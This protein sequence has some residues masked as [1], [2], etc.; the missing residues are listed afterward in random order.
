MKRLM[1][2]FIRSPQ[3]IVPAVS[4]ATIAVL[5]VASYIT[6]G[7]YAVRPNPWGEFRIRVI[8]TDF[9]AIPGASLRISSPDDPECE[10]PMPFGRDHSRHEWTSDSGGTIVIIEPRL[11]LD[12][13]FGWSLFW[14]IPMGGRA[15]LFEIEVLADGYETARIPLRRFCKMAREIPDGPRRHQGKEL[16]VFEMSVPLQKARK[17]DP[18]K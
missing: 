3:F 7:Y 4:L 18:G 9:N 1:F 15:E 6:T 12:D 14:V 11:R 13:S 5:A 16:P 10:A 8:D 2:R 17:R